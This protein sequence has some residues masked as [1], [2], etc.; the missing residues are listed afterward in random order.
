M[1]GGDPCNSECETSTGRIRKP[2][3]VRSKSEEPKQRDSG[4]QE[5][6]CS[7]RSAFG[8]KAHVSDIKQFMGL[9]L[10]KKGNWFAPSDGAKIA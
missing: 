1:S 10:D 4:Y 6:V 9:W 3:A 5:I 8:V 7:V 2:L